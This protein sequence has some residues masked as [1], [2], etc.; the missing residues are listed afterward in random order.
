M[1]AINPD[2]IDG[3]VYNDLTFQNGTRSFDDHGCC[4][5]CRVG[6]DE[7]CD[8]KELGAIQLKIMIASIK[9]E[10]KSIYEKD[11][12]ESGLSPDHIK[13]FVR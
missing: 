1:I 5:W 8:C 6:I 4:E 11:I 9:P 3:K 7:N 2:H 10:H 13:A 12:K